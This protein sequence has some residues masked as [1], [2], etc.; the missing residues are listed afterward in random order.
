MDNRETWMSA[1]GTRNPAL[2][3]FRDHF[4]AFD[5]WGSVIEAHFQ[6]CYTLARFDAAIPDEWEFSLGAFVPDL[7]DNNPDNSDSPDGS[8]LGWE[9]DLLL[10]QG[11]Y[12]NLIHAGNVLARLAAQYRLAGRDY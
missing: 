9:F 2:E 4:D 12:R 8:L 5:P 6:I 11:N 1:R 7:D 3:V 10:L